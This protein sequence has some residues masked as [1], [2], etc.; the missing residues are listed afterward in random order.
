MRSSNL[1]PT[2]LQNW[3]RLRALKPIDKHSKELI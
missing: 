2:P 1:K 3:F